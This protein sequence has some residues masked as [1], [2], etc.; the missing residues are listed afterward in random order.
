MKIVALVRIVL[1]SNCESNKTENL[2]VGAQHLAI[3]SA[4]IPE[5]IAQM[6]RPHPI[7]ND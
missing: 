6:L 7:L 4:V 2:G 3:A 5:V 1:D